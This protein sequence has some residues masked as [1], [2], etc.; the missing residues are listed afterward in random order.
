MD[1]VK[2]VKAGETVPSAD[3]DRGDDV[4]PGPGEG[5]SPDAASTESTDRGRRPGGGRHCLSSRQRREER[6]GRPS[7]P[8][9]LEMS[10]IDKAFVGVKA[11]DDVDFRLFPGEV[12]ALMGENGAGKSHADQ[13]ADRRLRDRR[14]RDRARRRSRCVRQPAGGPAR[15]AS[16]PCT[17]RSTSARTCRSPR[18][19]SSAASRAGSA[20]S[21][22]ARCAAARPR[23]SPRVDLDLDVVAPLGGYSLAVQ[24][25]VAIARAMDIAAQGADPRRADLEPGPG[26]GRAALRDHAQAE[27]ARGSR[28]SSSPTSSTRSTRSPTA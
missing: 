8:P 25:M 13:G 4:H 19:S 9:V 27:G 20:A 6:L 22:G 11:L 16:A 3:R 28:S 26:R 5:R 2:K 12:H 1:L 14:R 24:Q 21:S 23:R 18:T 7:S 17:R 10:G 15:P